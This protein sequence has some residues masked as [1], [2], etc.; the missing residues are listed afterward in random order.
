MTFQF[1]L[2][3]LLITAMIATAGALIMGVF[4]LFQDGKGASERSN[5]M[6]R[7]RV[8][9]QAIAIVVFSLLLFMQ[10]K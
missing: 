1:I 6:M 4:H 5:K 10:G 8:L 3:T 2:K 7:F 9:F